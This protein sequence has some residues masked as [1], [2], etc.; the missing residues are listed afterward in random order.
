M[1]E[2]NLHLGAAGDDGDPQARGQQAAD[3]RFEFHDALLDSLNG[4]LCRL[5]FAMLGAPP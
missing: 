3:G 2:W 1:E 5:T 4:G